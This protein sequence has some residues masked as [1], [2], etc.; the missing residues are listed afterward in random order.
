VNAL[1]VNVGSDIS[2]TAVDASTDPASG[3][4]FSLTPVVAPASQTQSGGT[5]VSWT[6][7]VDSINGTTYSLSPVPPSVKVL[8]A[9]CYSTTGTAP[10][11][12]EL[13]ATVLANTTLTWKV[14][15]GNAGAWLQAAEN[16]IIN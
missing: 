15:L 10:W 7:P 1:A 16:M 2:C 11:S 4:V 14:G 6:V 9:A 5:P 8:K 3:S 12:Q 13:T